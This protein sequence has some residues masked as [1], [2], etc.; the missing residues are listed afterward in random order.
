MQISDEITMICLFCEVIKALISESNNASRNK[1][2]KQIIAKTEMENNSCKS[3][4]K[5]L[6]EEITK[7]KLSGKRKLVIR[8]NN[9]TKKWDNQENKN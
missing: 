3:E 9:N 2:K 4:T 1:N 7:E 6:I 8:G 5:V